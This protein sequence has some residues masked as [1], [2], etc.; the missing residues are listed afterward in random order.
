MSEATGGYN[1]FVT[2]TPAN[3]R[4]GA[5]GSRTNDIEGQQGRVD[6]GTGPLYRRAQMDAD[7]QFAELQTVKEF[8]CILKG[9]KMD[10]A[11]FLDVLCWGNT[12]AVTD[13]TTSLQGQA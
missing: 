12:L 11:G 1:P 9:G 13:P 3:F 8:L 4:P 7:A 6:R 10:V 2:S 5:P